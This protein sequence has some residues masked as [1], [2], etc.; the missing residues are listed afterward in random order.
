MG[1]AKQY[2]GFVTVPIVDYDPG[3]PRSFAEQRA[4]IMSIAGDRIHA[5]EHVGSTAIP[6]LAAKPVVD[7][8]IA[9]ASVEADGAALRE[10]LAGLG[11]EFFDAGMPGRLFFQRNV[12]GRRT[13]HL[14]M[15]PIERWP[16]LKE[17]LF[18]D[19]LLDHPADRER[20]AELKRAIAR[21][22]P[23]SESYTRAKTAFVQEIVDAARAA[24]GLPSVPVWEGEA[25]RR[26]TVTPD[27]R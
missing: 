24:L 6:G 21:T 8:A 26:S 17:R 12:N 7:I 25:P 23:D 14:H 5:I 1:C 10:P 16:T 13:H 27:N 20:Y 18:R 15:L 11:F 4:A 19:W 22:A 9:V 3:W 2:R